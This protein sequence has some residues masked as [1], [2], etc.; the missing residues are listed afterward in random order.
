MKDTWGI[1][2]LDIDCAWSDNELKMHQDMN[3]TAAE[4]LEAAGALDIKP[5][6]RGPSTPGGNNHEM[7]PARMWGGIGKLQ[8]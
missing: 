2:T 3:V 8:Y 6:S 1:P 4:L 7:G 5:D